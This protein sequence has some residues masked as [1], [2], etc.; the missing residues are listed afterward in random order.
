M[1]YQERLSVPNMDGL[2]NWILHEAHGSLY[3]ILP[4][5]T[6]M[7][8]DLREVF[9]WEVLK[10]DIAEFVSKCPNFQ[11]VKDKHKKSEL[12]TSRNPTSYF[13]MGRHKC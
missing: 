9:C 6:M 2:R 4:D 1:R 13:E 7:Y 5:S 10:K 8:Y 3:S 11:Q 12:L